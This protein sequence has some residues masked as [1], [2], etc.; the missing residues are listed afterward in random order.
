VKW[1]DEYNL[2]KIKKRENTRK[3]LFFVCFYSIILFFFVSLLT[4]I[5]FYE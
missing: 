3:T 2:L 4:N 5:D 1:I